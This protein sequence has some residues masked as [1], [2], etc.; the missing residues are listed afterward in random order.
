MSRSPFQ[1]V[2]FHRVSWAAL[3]ILGCGAPAGGGGGAPGDLATDA[4][5]DTGTGFVPRADTSLFDAAA[6]PDAG[7]PE[8]A[9]TEQPLDVEI[10]VD[11]GPPAPDGPGVPDSLMPDTAL[12][13]DTAKPPVGPEPPLK[14]SS[15]GNG[16]G[17]ANGAPTTT[18]TGVTYRLIAKGGPGPHALLLVYSGTEGGATMTAN[19]NQV[20]PAFGLSAVIAVLDGMTYNGDAAAGADVLDDVRLA[21]DIDNDRTTLLSESAGTSAGLKLGFEVRQS[22]FAAFW[23]NDVNAS[24]TPQK[25]AAELGFAPWGNAGPG[26]AWAA[27]NAIV[28]GMKAAGYRSDGPTPYDGPGSGNHGDPNQFIAAVQWLVGKSRL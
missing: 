16:G 1:P 12:L 23:A 26:G 7:D 27:A 21:Y 8:P 20:A 18:P 5:H 2:L 6:L 15:G 19:L 10:S 28:G 4:A 13:P 11:E 22:Y 25:T 17:A 24:A 9:D 14:G 3:L